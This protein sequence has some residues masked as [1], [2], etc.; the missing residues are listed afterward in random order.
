MFGKL[1]QGLKNKAVAHM[2]E[3]QM[4]NVPPAQREMVTRMVQNNPQLFKKIADEIEAKKKEG[5]PEMYAAIEVMKKYQSE[6]QKLS[7]Q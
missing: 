1:F 6:L 4:K 2:V 7:G 3:K 5:K